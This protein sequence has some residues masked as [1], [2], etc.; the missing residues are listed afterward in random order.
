MDQRVC[1]DQRL[2][3]RPAVRF[4]ATAKC[5]PLVSFLKNIPS[6][7][8]VL[9][10]RV[11]VCTYIHIYNLGHFIVH[12]RFE[13]LALPSSIRIRQSRVLFAIH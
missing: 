12:L 3:F 1:D 4:T 5:Q 7:D 6:Y 8:A 11:C 13:T 2:V 10:A 9:R